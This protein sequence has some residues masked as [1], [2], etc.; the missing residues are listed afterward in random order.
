MVAERNRLAREEQK[1]AAEAYY[2]EK[3]AKAATAAPKSASDTKEESPNSGG[4]FGLST[5]Q[6]IGIGGFGV[7]LLGIYY[8]REEIMAMTKPVFDKFK[9]PEPAP[10]EPAS[11]EAEPARATRP[12]VL[13]KCFERLRVIYITMPSLAQVLIHAAAIGGITLFWANFT[14]KNW[15]MV[16]RLTDE[17][18]VEEGERRKKMEQEVRRKIE[19]EDKIKEF[20][21]EEEEAERQVPN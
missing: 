7:S 5:N 9:T 14:V 15:R 6:W 8:K 21:E 18:L 13:K 2:A 11:V 12:R 3:Q 10:P 16:R 4:L 20:A 17:M 1:K 19:I